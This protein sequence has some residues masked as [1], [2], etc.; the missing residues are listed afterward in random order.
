LT[1]SGLLSDPFAIFNS[2][3]PDGTD[4]ARFSGT[5]AADTA[6]PGRYTIRLD[7]TVAA[8]PT[9]STVIYQANDGQLFWLDENSNGAS[10]FLGSLQQQGSLAAL[11]AAPSGSRPKP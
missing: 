1:A 2:T 8:D 7:I 4:T 6:N 10:V 11:P 3:Q 5:A 9:Y